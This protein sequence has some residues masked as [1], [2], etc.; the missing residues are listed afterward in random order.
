MRILTMLTHLH[1]ADRDQAPGSRLHLRRYAMAVALALAMCRGAAAAEYYVA[2]NGDDARSKAQ[3]TNLASPWKTINAS[4]AKLV[5]G[6]TLRVRGGTYAE[7]VYIWVSGT[8]SAPIT[9]AAYLNEL[10][11]IDGEQRIPTGQYAALMN[12]SGNYL[13]V[14][15]FE[16]KNSNLG[17]FARG[18]SMYGTNNRLSKCNVH[19]VYSNGVLIQ[20]DNGIVEDCVVWQSD[21]AMGLGH[22]NGWASGLTAARGTSTDGGFTDNAIIRRNVVFNNWGE[23]L[24]T[25]EANGTIIE[26]NI[27]YDN[28]AQN[29]YISDASNVLCQRNIIYRTPGNAVGP[30]TDC[31]L[32]DEL[33]EKPRSTNNKIINNFFYGLNFSAFSWSLPPGSGLTNALIAN[34]TFVDAQLRLGS[35]NSGVRIHN[36][37]FTTQGAS[38]PS[39]AGITWSNN[40]WQ[41]TR[42]ANAVGTGDV[43]GDPRLAKTGPTGPGQLTAAFFRITSASSPAIGSGITMAEVAED[44]FRVVRSASPD[45]GAHEYNHTPVATAQSVTTTAGTAKVITL[46]GTDADGNALTYAIVANPAHGTLTGS[47]ATR[48][49][50]PAGGYSGADSFTFTV[51]DG[52][53]TSTAATVS[54]SVTASGNTAPTVGSAIASPATVAATTTALSATASDDAGEAGLTYTWS[55]SPATVSFS[56]NGSNAAKASTATFTAAG[57]YVLTITARDAGGLSGTRA[58]TVV[59]AATPTSLVISPATAKVASGASLSLTA[60]VKDQFQ[61]VI[62]SPALSWTVVSGGGSVG[63]NGV[64]SAPAGTGTATVRAVSGAASA[65]STLTVGSTIGAIVGGDSGGSAGGSC[66]SGAL[67]LLLL[68]GL[69]VLGLCNPQRNRAC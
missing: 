47:G 65:T 14:T 52:T 38:V 20:G 63:A 48:T 3:A 12:L 27:I 55:A 49:Y 44:Y 25:Y 18:V 61:A 37:V 45:I 35:I 13:H 32:A 58:V 57:T 9:V 68:V 67:G 21:L 40:L 29:L 6:D 51:S 2:T 24:S 19:H 17:N 15:G 8:A 50:T 36:N 43:F 11:V 1:A 64:Y 69:G 26:D 16:I 33:P 46:A 39:A 30:N 22:W 5:P 34:N 41:G 23:G 56:P 66:G 31:A 54:I 4:V 42:P 10:P 59:V 62:A 60:T 28:Q 53:A 7:A